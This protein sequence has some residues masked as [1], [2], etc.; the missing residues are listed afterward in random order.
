MKGR[1]T[2]TGGIVIS[3]RHEKKAYAQLPLRTETESNTKGH[4]RPKAERARIQREMA[5]NVVR[6]LRACVPCVVTME[7]VSPGTLDDDNLGSALKHVRDGIA[8]ALGV[9]DRDPR[10]SF[11]Y[12]QK[13][14]SRGNYWVDVLIEEAAVSIQLPIRMPAKRKARA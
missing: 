3:C 7:R 12:G 8:D 1:P 2:I 5:R 6:S 9:D 14:R 4:W 11:V 10:V 13:S